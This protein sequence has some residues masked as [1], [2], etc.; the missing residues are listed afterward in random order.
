MSER[1]PDTVFIDN[2]TWIARSMDNLQ[3][4]LAIA[5]SFCSLNDIW[6]NNDKATL[7]TNNHTY[8]NKQYALQINSTS[9]T[10]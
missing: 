5:Q 1:I 6:I 10:V 8:A 9:T 4:I 3:D 7:L 2:T